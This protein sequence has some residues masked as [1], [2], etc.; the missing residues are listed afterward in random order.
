MQ[1]FEDKNGHAHCRAL[2]LR[3]SETIHIMDGAL[4]MGRWQRLFLIECDRPRL[5][6]VD[7][8]ILGSRS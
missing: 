5:R 3:T 4:Q 1:P 2:F 8:L 6:T 7:V